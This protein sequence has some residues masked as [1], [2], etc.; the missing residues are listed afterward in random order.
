MVTPKIPKYKDL[1]THDPQVRVHVTYALQGGACKLS[2]YAIDER[3]IRI[4]GSKTLRRYADTLSAIPTIEQHLVTAV[5]AAVTTAAA[6]R[7]KKLA[8]DDDGQIVKAFRQAVDSNDPITSSWGASTR[9]KRLTY[10]ERNVLPVIDAHEGPWL[11]EDTAALRDA[12]IDRVLKNKGSD[13]ALEVAEDTVDNSLA[14]SAVIYGRLCEISPALPE[15]DLRP[16][17]YARKRVHK[18]QFKSLPDPVRRKLAAKLESSI[19]SAPRKVMAT[20]VMYDSGLR[21]AEAAAVHPDELIRRELGIS[22]LVG[23]QESEGKRSPILKTNSAYRQ[24]PT[25]YWGAAMINRCIAEIGVLAPDEP[26]CSSHELSAWIRELLV[27][28]GCNE[29]L[30]AAAAREQDEH[31]DRDGSGRPIRDLSAYILRRDWASRA[32]NVCGFTQIEIDYLLGHK[33]RVPKKARLDF[34]HSDLQAFLSYKLERYIHDYE[35]SNH[36][37]NTP[38]KIIHGSDETLHAFGGYKISNAGNEPL[39][40]SLDIEAATNAENIVIRLPH[41]RKLA[42][43]RRVI[44]TKGMRQGDPVIGVIPLDEKGDDD[45]G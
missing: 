28:C 16:R 7:R 4:D 37:W 44:N 22:I 43:K 19:S 21:T 31:P 1:P 8:A 17:L 34:R 33:I 40:V 25:S 2:G 24:A 5:V 30:L 20:T 45:D 29:V 41:G 36:P 42:A 23:F 14:A 10:F 32:R 39:L 3:G 12:L 26:L 6:K 27:E 35:I 38:V 18:E 15:I 11:A 9:H 13:G